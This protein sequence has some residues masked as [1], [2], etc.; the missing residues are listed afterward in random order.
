MKKLFG[1]KTETQTTDYSAVLELDAGQT[2]LAPG[3]QN[4]YSP[5]ATTQTRIRDVAD[6]LCDQEQ[7]TS[8]QVDHIV[9]EG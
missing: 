5:Q 6:V 2:D 9:P 8:E 7:L 1:K 4:L 3:L